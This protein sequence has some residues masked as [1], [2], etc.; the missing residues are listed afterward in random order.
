M[1]L[2]CLRQTFGAFAGSVRQYDARALAGQP[3]RHG[4]RRAARAQY[5]DRLTPHDNARLDKRLK[6]AASVR[7]VA[8]QPPVQAMHGI[9]RAHAARFVRD[10]VQKGQRTLFV[11]DGQVDAHDAQTGQAAKR[12]ANR[13]GSNLKRHIHKRQI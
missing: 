3:V 2:R 5:Q 7:V 8:D 11:R 1:R 12:G 9:D 13:V 4:P 6:K 10:L